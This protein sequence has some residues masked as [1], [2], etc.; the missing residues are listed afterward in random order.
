MLRFIKSKLK[1][2]PNTIVYKTKEGEEQSLKDVF[3]DIGIS[4]YELSIDALDMHAHQQTFQR[5]DKFNAKYN[6][7]NKPQLRTVF[8][9]IDNHINGRFLAEITKEVFA[10]LKDNKHQYAEYRLSIYGKK[11][12]EWDILA[13]WIC[14]YNLFSFNVRWLIQMPRIYQVL[15]LYFF[16]LFLLI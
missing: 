8:L 5:F 3:D 9:K 14:T 6:P 4:A 13:D 1:K 10:D 7:V 12:E 2:E 11:E 16:I 15:F